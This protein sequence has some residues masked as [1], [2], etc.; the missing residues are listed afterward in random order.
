MK[1]IFT[2]DKTEKF[3]SLVSASSR[4]AV[5][6]HT[7]PD[8]DAIGAGLALTLFL[9][10]KFGSSNPKFDVRFIVP[11]RFPAFLN[12]VDPDGKIDIFI[13]SC[14]YNESFLAAA[15]LIII[16]DFNDVR[17]LEAMGAALDLNISAPR[18]LIDHHIAP[19]LY[20]LMFHSTESSSTAFLVYSLIESL[21]GGFTP[22]IAKALYLGM[23]TD[24][25]SFAFGNLTADLF[26]AVATLVENGLDVP[27]VN[28][29]VYNTQSEDRV[30][31]QGYLLSEKM[32]VRLA[33]HAAYITLT[34]DEKLRF[35]HQIGDT[36][37]F[38]NI[39]LTIQGVEFSAMLIQTKECVKL[40]LR[41]VGELDVNVIARAHF[42]GGGHKNAAGGKFFGTMD[43]AIATLEAVIA[44]L[45]F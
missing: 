9:S 4:V 24:T 17:R 13:D 28:R 12:W 30:R 23:M 31:M 20:D 8:G 40:S 27:A 14:K 5:I 45:K 1:N 37:G 16:V 33:H 18:I 34:S 29:S 42:N 41:S 10:Q 36:E 26:R 44:D 38:V 7:N 43:E 6:A 19:P 35:N 21:G 25:G 39:P 22:A 2:P 15:D 32:E 3:S 11:N